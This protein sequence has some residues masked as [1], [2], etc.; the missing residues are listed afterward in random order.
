MIESIIVFVFMAFLAGLVTYLQHNDSWQ[1]NYSQKGNAWANITSTVFLM[2]VVAI[3][4]HCFGVKVGM[5]REARSILIDGKSHYKVVETPSSRDVVEKR[6][7]I[8]EEE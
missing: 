3:A 2:L 4:G 8:V 5:E 1:R 6:S 7:R